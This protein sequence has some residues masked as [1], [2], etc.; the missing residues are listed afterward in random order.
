MRLAWPVIVARAGVMAMALADIVMVGHYATRE[1]AYLGI[2]IAP[3]MP[4]FLVLLGLLLG[5]AVVT[6]AALG[7]GRPAECGAAW[8]RSLPYSVVLGLLGALVTAFGEPL[9]LAAGQTP[10]LAANGGRIM[11][12]LGL[13]LPAYLLYITSALFL[14]GVRNPKP[15]MLMMI[16]ANIV[17]IGLNWVLI[18][19]HLGFPAMGAEGSAITSTLV[20]WLLMASLLAYIWTMPGHKTYGVRLAP[21]GGWKD[22]AGQRRVGYSA[23]VSIGVESL[24]FSFMGIFAGWLG[25]VALAS[26]SIAQNLLAMAFMVSLGF[27]AATGV[28]VAIASG[29]GDMDDRNLAGWTGFGANVV[30]MTGVGLI[31][32]SLADVLAAG[33][34]ND[35]IVVAATVPLIVY[36]AFITVTDGGQAV[37]VHALRSSGGIWAPALIQSF[38][39]LG[40]MVPL[41]WLL[42]LQLQHGALGLFQAMLVASAT[43]LILLSLRF[44]WIAHS[45][46]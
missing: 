17:N 45:P 15:A 11:F 7:A 41:A 42:A 35:L 5:T 20:R 44:R 40:L 37:M 2:G 18:Y 31:F 39:F 29:R 46:H 9:L 33:Y 13:G 4:V 26:F 19:G 36:C 30:T 38:C 6:S 24:A 14:E 3:F 12:W 1:L 10:E 21:E 28:R 23:A 25:T 8:R 43:S 16:A 32:M 34:S 27:G 22:W